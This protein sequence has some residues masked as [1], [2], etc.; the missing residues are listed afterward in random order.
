MSANVMPIFIQYPQYRC[1]V[2]L[3]SSRYRY[4]IRLLQCWSIWCRYLANIHFIYLC[5]ITAKM[6]ANMMPI[7]SQYSQYR[8]DVELISSQYCYVVLLLQRW[9]IWCRY[10]A[11]IHNIGV[12]LGWDHPNI[13]VL[14]IYLCDITAKMLANMMPIFSQYSQ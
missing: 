3:R 13:Y 8:R 7:F 12:M 11:N 2:R 6:L 9:P 4:V 1:D 5:D 10:L 14:F